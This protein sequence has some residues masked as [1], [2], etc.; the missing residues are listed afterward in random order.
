MR[1]MRLPES[2]DDIEQYADYVAEQTADLD[3][4]VLVGDSFGAVIAL[5]LATRQPDGLAG[6]V[7]S[8]GFAVSPV[9]NP[10]LRARIKA[11]RLLP[12]PLYRAVTLRLHADSLSS[13]HDADGEIPWSKKRSRELFVSNTPYRSYV[14]RAKAALSADYREALSRIEIPTLILTPSHDELIGPKA[15]EIMLDGISD[16][17][18]VVLPKTGHMFRFSHPGRYSKAVETFI[19]ERVE[20]TTQRSRSSRRTPSASQHAPL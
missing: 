16:A 9:E 12:G 3:R 14:A 6:L 18:E 17:R 8:G 2:L 20:R 5:A 7:L 19:Q 13:P 4:Y 1:T 10:L 15:T 11:A